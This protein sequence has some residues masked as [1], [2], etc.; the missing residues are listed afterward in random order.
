[1]TRV[2]LSLNKLGSLPDPVFV[3]QTKEVL[4]HLNLSSNLLES[5]PASLFELDNLKFLDVSNN[6]LISLPPL[7]SG[8]IC[9]FRAFGNQIT[10]LPAIQMENLEILDMKS[11]KISVLPEDIGALHKLKKVCLDDNFLTTVPK[12]VG[13]LMQLTDLSL[14]KNKLASVEEDALASLTGLVS[15]DL[16]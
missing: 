8:T 14:A 11:N 9:E 12:F 10:A 15:L 16:H 4:N 13:K 5:I 3:L 6:K 7:V 2:D 1:L